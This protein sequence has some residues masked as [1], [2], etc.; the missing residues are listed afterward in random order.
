MKPL[1]ELTLEDIKNI[2]LLSFDAD[3][4]TVELG[5]EVIETGELLT[6]KTK[7]I[8]DSLIAKLQKLKKYFH[9]NISSGR[10][11][12]YLDRMFGPVLWDKASIQGE[13]GLFTLIDGK[14]IQ[15]DALSYDELETIEKIRTE[16]KRLSLTDKNIKGFE[17]K[18]FMISAHCEKQDLLIE[19]IVRRIDT[20]QKFNSFWVSNESHDIYLKRFDKGTGL[21]FLANHLGLSLDQALAVG[22][23]VNDKP[24]LDKAG[25]GITTNPKEVEAYFYTESKLD[26]GGKEVVDRLLE[27]LG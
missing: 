14:I 27:I 16:I 11:L 20:D 19:D 22:N 8:T 1:S 15:T 17:P 2:K 23:G 6:V 9:I 10:N 21:E 25:I 5:T 4:V 24:M 13:N 26:L 18:Q 12:L 7:K 3:G